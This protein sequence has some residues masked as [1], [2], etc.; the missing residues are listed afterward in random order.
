MLTG[1]AFSVKIKSRRESE[2][3]YGWQTVVTILRKWLRYDETTSEFFLVGLRKYDMITGQV[4]TRVP[5]GNGKYKK[6]GTMKIHR[7]FS[8]RTCNALNVMQ[9]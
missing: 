7:S 3:K 5:K 1:D 9:I 4:I 2:K 8:C 6:Y